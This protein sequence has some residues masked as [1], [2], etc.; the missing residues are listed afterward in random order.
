[1]LET[2]EQ[3]PGRNKETQINKTYINS[4]SYKRKFDLITDSPEL[5]RLL[6]HLSKKMLL[7]RS[8]TRY[9]DMYWINLDTDSVIAEEINCTSEK[10]VEYSEKTI[11]AINS[12]S[13]ILTIHSHPDSFPP[14]I[15]DINSNFLHQ[16]VAG[17]VVGHDGKVY[18][19][20]ANEAVN[21]RYYQLIV[22][23]NLK[24]GY[25]ETEA[26]VGAL[27]KLTECF[28]ITFKEVTDNGI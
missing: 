16:Y 22:E 2:E 7:H 15:D 26:Q 1:M 24:S 25:N 11:R 6:Y 14:S 27:K 28:S 8:G 17:I 9:E 21:T 3:R 5:S 4:G 12:C 10:R 18:L 19:Y 23:E 13:N 20:S